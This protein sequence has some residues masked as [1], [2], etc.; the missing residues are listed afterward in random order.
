MLVTGH[1][2]VDVWEAVKPA[3]VGIRAWP[4]VPRGTDWKT[5]VCASLRWGEPADGAR[6][7]GGQRSEKPRA[8]SLF[9]SH[10]TILLKEKKIVRTSTGFGTDSV[11]LM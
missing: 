5:G 11:W 7:L 4:Q 8:S 3:T 2:Y 1:Q 6:R 9:F 10:V